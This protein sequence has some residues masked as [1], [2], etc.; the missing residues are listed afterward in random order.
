[1]LA[2]VVVLGFFAGVKVV[3]FINNDLYRKFILVVT[4]I[5]AIFILAQ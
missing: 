2:P 1:M 3:Q 5:G 4:G